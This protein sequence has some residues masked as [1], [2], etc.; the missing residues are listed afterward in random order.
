MFDNSQ[1]KTSEEIEEKCDK[2]RSLQSRSTRLALGDDEMKWLEK[3]FRTHIQ[4]CDEMKAAK[5]KPKPEPTY[6]NATQ[7]F[8]KLQAYKNLHIESSLNDFWAEA[9]PVSF[10]Q[11][12]LVLANW[13]AIKYTLFIK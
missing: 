12:D 2:I 4:I 1:R 10:V 7:D 5:E 3:F 9:A 13:I 8:V 6:P 11:M